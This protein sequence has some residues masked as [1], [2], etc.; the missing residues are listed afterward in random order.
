VGLLK[1]IVSAAQ[2]GDICLQQRFPEPFGNAD[3]TVALPSVLL[4]CAVQC[5][6]ASRL[7]I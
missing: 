1:N 4:L 5:A 3:I 6:V 2:S 7:Q